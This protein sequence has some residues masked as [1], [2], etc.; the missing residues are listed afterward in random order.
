LL[1]LVDAGRGG[2]VQKTLLAFVGVLILFGQMV[3]VGGCANQRSVR[4]VLPELSQRRAPEAEIG[5]ETVLLDDLPKYSPFI[6]TSLISADGRV[7]VFVVDRKDHLNHFEIMGDQILTREV[8][9]VV[10]TD[11][12]DAIEYPQGKLRVLAGNRQYIRPEP[13]QGWQEVKGNRCSKFVPTADKLLCAFVV[14]GEEVN[15][16]YRKDTYFGVIILVPYVFWKNVQA[17]KLVIAEETADNEWTIRAVLDPDTVMSANNRFM[18]GA[19]RFDTL[20][21]LYLTGRG[22]AAFFFLVGAATGGGVGGGAGAGGWHFYDPELRYAKISLNQLFSQPE[23]R[24]IDPNQGSAHPSWMT[25]KG[26]T[27]SLDLFRVFPLSDL[28]SD[29]GEE[30]GFLLTPLDRRFLVEK[31]SGKV[32]GL[33]DSPITTTSDDIPA[34]YFQSPRYAPAQWGCVEAEI[35]NDKLLLSL[36]KIVTISDE[37]GNAPVLVVKQDAEGTIHALVSIG[38]KEEGFLPKAVYY[39]QKNGPT[40]SQPLLLGVPRDIH[41]DELLLAAN[42]D[43]VIYAAWVDKERRLIGRWII[44]KSQRSTTD[45][46]KGTEGLPVRG[47]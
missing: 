32:K 22:G 15:A 27:V 41:S 7:H 11:S 5:P 26:V 20:H 43:G 39:V 6:G 42:A 1:A 47:H 35:S 17:S 29:F 44:L 33:A 8:I 40:W 14:K 4:E 34:F 45:K 37:H 2:A 23:S 18:I 3:L 12:V 13:H 36:D 9:G 46:Q 30:L 24:N 19:D 25:V 38:S 10:E 28:L 21:F 16:P 31:T